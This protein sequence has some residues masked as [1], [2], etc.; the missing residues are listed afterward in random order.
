MEDSSEFVSVVVTV[1]VTVGVIFVV[2]GGNVFVDD[3]CVSVIVAVFAFIEL[4]VMRDDIVC[5]G[6]E[7]VD[8]FSSVIVCVGASVVA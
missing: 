8:D 3:L 4:I 6:F 7:G 2:I 5:T 1:T